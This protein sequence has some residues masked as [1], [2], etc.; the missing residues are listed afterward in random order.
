MKRADAILKLAKDI[1]ELRERKAAAEAELR[2]VTD[3]L[4]ERMARFSTL[5]SSRTRISPS[6]RT[7]ISPLPV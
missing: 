4:R 5:V 2:G 6:V 1:Q 7:G 3:A